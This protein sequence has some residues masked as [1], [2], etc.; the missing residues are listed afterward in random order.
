[1]CQM[2]RSGDDIRIESTMNEA[3][4]TALEHV[5][6]LKSKLFEPTWILQIT[7]IDSYWDELIHSINI[8]EFCNTFDA[9]NKQNVYAYNIHTSMYRALTDWR[10]EL[11]TRVANRIA[12]FVTDEVSG[13]FVKWDGAEMKLLYEM[14]L[15]YEHI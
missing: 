15:A 2:V 13:D 8:E 3:F 11:M 5:G 7:R 14:N 12:Q 4:K 9:I 10:I 6:F 1:M